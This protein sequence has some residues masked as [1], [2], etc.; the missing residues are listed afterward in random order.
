MARDNALIEPD[1]YDWEGWVSYLFEQLEVEAQRRGKGAFYKEM[2]RSLK[3][4]LGNRISL[5]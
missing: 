4:D 2:L 3:Q 5:D 1:P